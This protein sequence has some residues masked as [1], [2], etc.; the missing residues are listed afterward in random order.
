MYYSGQDWHRANATLRIAAQRAIPEHDE[1]IVRALL[2]HSGHVS[3]HEVAPATLRAWARRI[4][5]GDGARM[6]AFVARHLRLERTW[7]ARWHERA[8]RDAHRALVRIASDLGAGA[9][10][11]AMHG[12]DPW[13]ICDVCVSTLDTWRERLRRGEPLRWSERSL[14]DALDWPGGV[15]P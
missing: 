10:V 2:T 8:W 7:G 1:A 11:E 3:A 6:R 5:T 12:G 13:V 4:R 14:A 15:S 9:Q